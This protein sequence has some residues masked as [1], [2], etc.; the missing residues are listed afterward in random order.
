MIFNNSQH[1]NLYNKK[2]LIIVYINKTSVFWSVFTDH[3]LH[4]QKKATTNTM[5]K[6]KNELCFSLISYA[7]C[8]T[9]NKQFQSNCRLLLPSKTCTIWV[10]I[11]LLLYSNNSLSSFMLKIMYLHW[12]NL[13]SSTPSFPSEWHYPF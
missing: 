7:Y 1:F 3:V 9:V 4:V 6:H 2:C 13:C 11:F 8:K 12:W 10:H 5:Y